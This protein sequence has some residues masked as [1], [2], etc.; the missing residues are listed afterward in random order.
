MRQ[1]LAA[2]LAIAPYFLWGATS[3]LSLW[4][5]DM[6]LGLFSILWTVWWFFLWMLQIS[7][8]DVQFSIRPDTCSVCFEYGGLLDAWWISLIG[9]ICALTAMYIAHNKKIDTGAK[10]FAGFIGATLL[11]VFSLAQLLNSYVTY[12]QFGVNLAVALVL[13]F[14]A[15]WGLSYVFLKWLRSSEARDFLKPHTVNHW[16]LGGGDATKEDPLEV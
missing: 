9:A 2:T 14:P 10:I 11:L 12:G 8:S 6:L 13:V 5:N 16:F 3:S 15:I 1:A 7:L 4:N